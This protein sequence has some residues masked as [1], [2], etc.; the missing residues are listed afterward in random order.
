MAKKQGQETVGSPQPHDLLT[1]RFVTH[2]NLRW[3]LGIGAS[4]WDSVEWVLA[5]ESG[6]RRTRTS[7]FAVI[8]SASLFFVKWGTAE[9]LLIFH[10]QCCYERMPPDVE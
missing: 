6:A 8:A 1:G 10:G 7:A 2:C 5:G 4:C 3:M 9:R